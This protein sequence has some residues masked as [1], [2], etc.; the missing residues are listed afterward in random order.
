MV[1][2]P[3]L[4]SCKLAVMEM[5]RTARALR[6]DHV[7]TSSSQ[8]LMWERKAD[9]AMEPFIVAGA[10]ALLAAQ[11][12]GARFGHLPDGPTVNANVEQNTADWQTARR[13]AKVVIEAAWA[14][15]A[16]EPVP[17]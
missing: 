6:D 4:A 14:L 8:A 10:R 15:E 16:S 9:E 2:Y 3:N 17:A 12:G 13:H 11:Y 7:I 5:F 1:E